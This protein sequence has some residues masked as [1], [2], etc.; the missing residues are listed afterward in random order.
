MSRTTRKAARY[1]ADIKFPFHS[2]DA[3]DAFRQLRERIP[4]G[5][6]IRVTHDVSWS[7]FLIWSEHRTLEIEISRGEFTVELRGDTFEE[8]LGRFDETV[9]PKLT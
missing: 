5:F 6:E 2:L 4:D 7:K 1:S 3:D 8:I 9:L